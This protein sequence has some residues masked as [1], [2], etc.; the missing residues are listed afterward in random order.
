MAGDE[1]DKDPESSEEAERR[2]GERRDGGDRRAMHDG[3]QDGIERRKGDR[4]K[5]ERRLK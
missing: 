1:T 5:G 3:P 2:S 4:R